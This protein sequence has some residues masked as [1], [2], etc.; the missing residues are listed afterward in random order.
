MGP[1][2]PLKLQIGQKYKFGPIRFIQVSF[3]KISLE[4]HKKLR[5]GDRFLKKMKKCPYLKIENGFQ[6]YIN[7]YKNGSYMGLK[8]P[9][10][11]VQEVNWELDVAKKSEIS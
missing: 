9:K 2:K 6:Q 7:V 5:R 1:Q 3:V 4:R 8:F 11:N 10:R